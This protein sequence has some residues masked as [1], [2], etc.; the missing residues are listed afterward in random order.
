MRGRLAPGASAC[1]S[2]LLA[3]IAGIYIYIYIYTTIQSYT[4]IIKNNFSSVIYDIRILYIRLR[5]GLLDGRDADA[6]GQKH[7]ATFAG[8]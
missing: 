8:K 3:A 1:N 7:Y 5:A 4:I 2:R 6:P